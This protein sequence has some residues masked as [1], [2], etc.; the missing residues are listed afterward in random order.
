MVMNINL[1][2]LVQFLVKAKRNTYAGRG[3]ETVGPDGSKNLQYKEGDYVYKDRYFGSERFGGEE[4]VWLKGKAVWLMNYNGG[5]TKKI[6][7]SKT[8]FSFLRKAL[9]QVP[10]DS[11]FRGPHFYKEGDF[12]YVDSSS[13]DITCFRG[14]EEILYHGEIVHRVEYTG[15]IIKE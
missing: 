14:T 13:G 8:V 6:V 2:E 10:A 12:E 3:A 11:P 4:V 15:G 1:H 5:I 9:L 7:D